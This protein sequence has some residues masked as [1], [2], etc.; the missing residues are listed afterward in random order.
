MTP[1]FDTETQFDQMSEAAS[2]FRIL[3]PLG[4]KN[5]PTEL[6]PSQEGMA[7]FGSGSGVEKGPLMLR[8]PWSWIPSLKIHI[9][10]PKK[11]RKIEK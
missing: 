10:D 5:T 8:D 4:G 1:G 6:D 2:D 3:T 9:R 11:K 7:H